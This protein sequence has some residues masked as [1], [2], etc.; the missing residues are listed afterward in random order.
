[1]PSTNTPLPGDLFVRGAEFR[2]VEMSGEL[3][4]D[5]GVE[6]LFGVGWTTFGS[7]HCRATPMA[8]WLEWAASATMFRDGKPVGE[9]VQ[10]PCLCFADDYML[11]E[12]G[13]SIEFFR[14]RTAQP[15]D[16]DVRMADV[17]VP[18]QQPQ[19]TA[20]EGQQTGATP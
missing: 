15:G 5:N 20:G 7:D 2:H 9:C 17:I 6:Y 1:M 12:V 10:V 13:E 11:G 8:E 19:P 4:V 14:L 16:A 3:T 18:P